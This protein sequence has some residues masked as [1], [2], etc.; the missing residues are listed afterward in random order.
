MKGFKIYL[1]CLLSFLSFFISVNLVQATPL[2]V[3]LDTSVYASPTSNVHYP[4]DEYI[5]DGSRTVFMEYKLNIFSGGTA[6]EGNP[7]EAFCIDQSYYDGNESTNYELLTFDQY[8]D[9]ANESDGTSEKIPTL[10]H[11]GQL[12]RSAWI[13][14]NKG[15]SDESQ[16][17]I[18]EIMFDYDDGLL[19]S[20]TESN[21][22]FNRGDTNSTAAQVYVN[23]AL[24]ATAT[25][26]SGLTNYRIAYNPDS[27]DY[28]VKAVPI[29]STVAFLVAGIFGLIPFRK[30]ILGREYRV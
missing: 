12:K 10:K 2:N 20:G 4:R 27:Q 16:L 22:Y 3:S 30:K 24:S 5:I 11:I 23:N 18:W 8:I 28:L 25:D 19:S 29:P 7:Q 14:E 26:L 21:F 13:W 6:W 9:I 17:A 1:I 15:W